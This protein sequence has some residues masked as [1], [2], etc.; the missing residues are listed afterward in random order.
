[1]MKRKVLLLALISVLM[2]CK[3]DSSNNE[4]AQN[5][6]TLTSSSGKLNNI[7]IV[8]SNAMWEGKVG[9]TI[10]DAMAQTVNGLPQK[11]PVFSINHI[12]PK[13]FTGFVK[14]KRTILKVER[15]KSKGFAI[16]KNEHATPQ[17]V[18]YVKGPDSAA[19]NRVLE[20]HQKEIIQEFKDT[21]I[22]EQ[23]RRIHKS[24]LDDK[25]IEE[26]IG[27]SLDIPSAY[28]Y[29]KVNS[30]FIWLRKSIN[31]GDMGL[32]IYKVPMREIDKDTNT[33]GNII[34]IR[35]SIGKEYIP[36]PN[37]E[38]DYMQTEE[39]YAP[40][41]FESKIDNHFAYE[42]RGTWEVK[43]FTMAGPFLNFA[44]RDEADKCYVVL[45]GFVFR[46]SATKRD[47]IFEIEAILRS[48]QFK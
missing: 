3:N 37:E 36:G 13:A 18:V 24:L 48:A 12:P 25:K 46:P 30:D 21:E 29:A 40:Y 5:K 20:T 41:L 27:V 10:R 44:V 2:A 14:K 23:Q 39:A 31:N 32:L 45:E 26:N 47:Q 35:D 15:D 17:I 22:K 6:V 38:T 16:K 1:M 19:I 4:S 42:S 11:E 33:I 34:R 43:G 7:A 8:T 28:R 9:E